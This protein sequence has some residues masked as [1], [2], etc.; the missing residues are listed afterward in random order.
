MLDRVY[1]ILSIIC[2]TC[3]VVLLGLGGWFWMY[4]PEPAVDPP[5][6]IDEPEREVADVV[7]GV[8]KEVSFTLH[9]P[10]PRSI[11]VVGLPAC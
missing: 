6:R 5:V 11:R 4:P 7:A 2:M 9:N 10:R 8:V 3:G 1:G